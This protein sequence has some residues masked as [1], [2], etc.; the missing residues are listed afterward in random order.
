M[1]ARSYRAAAVACVAVALAAL[2]LSGCASAR[3]IATHP[4]ATRPPATATPTLAW[5]PIALPPGAI[6]YSQANTSRYAT[7]T[8]SPVDAHNLWFCVPRV[9]GGFAIWATADAGVSWRQVSIFAPSAPEQPSCDLIAD[10]LDA[11]I[12]VARATWGSGEAGTLRAASYLS[13]D[14]GATWRALPGDT[15]ITAIASANGVNYTILQDTANPAAQPGIAISTDGLRTWRAV[16]PADLAPNDGFFQF[17]LQPT[18][19]ELLAA[20]YQNTL[21][22]SD[23]RGATWARVSTPDLQVSLGAWIGSQQRWLLC[24][25]TQA[26]PP[27][28]M[29]GT[30]TGAPWT[31]QPTFTYT[32][33]CAHCGKNGAPYSVTDT[34]W[35]SDIAADGALVAACL[36]NGS[37][38]NF[39]QF[40]AAKYVLYRLAPGAT[41]WA[42]LGAAPG[43]WLTV[44]ATGPLWCWNAQ[45]GVLSQA[46]LP[47]L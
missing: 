39:G 42:T 47:A 7:F 17:W 4:T 28:L 27:Q 21:W 32:L 3:P 23:D 45:Q 2:S 12:L 29:C 11:R 6:V 14:S 46:T 37:Q 8:I 25:G 40:D 10:Q 34:C 18:T 15:L 35:P 33:A 36:A 30:D 38:P 16:R 22:R 1:R 44:A 26:T 31:P 43:P 24:G 9:A 20:S 41:T 19:H 13:S 5:R